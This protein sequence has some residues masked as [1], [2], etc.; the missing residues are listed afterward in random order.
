MGDRAKQLEAF[1]RSSD[2]SKVD[3]AGMVE[4]E[5]AAR[6][7]QRK[8]LFKTAKELQ[9]ELNATYEAKERIESEMEEKRH[10]IVIDQELL[11]ARAFME[12][13]TSPTSRKP[14]D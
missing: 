10:T 1:F 7:E 11:R 9:A 5:E 2:N 4:N 3:V 6:R 14:S 13:S 8:N 12:V